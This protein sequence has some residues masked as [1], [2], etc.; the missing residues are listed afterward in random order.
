MW[1]TPTGFMSG[2][3]VSLFE[4]HVSRADHF[5]ECLRVAAG[6]GVAAAPGLS[7]KGAHHLLAVGTS[8]HTQNVMWIASA[9]PVKVSAHR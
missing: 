6:V 3:A 7:A 2:E 1:R 9:L 8:R 4:E 5:V